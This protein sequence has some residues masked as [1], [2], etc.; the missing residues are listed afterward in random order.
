MFGGFDQQASTDRT[1]FRV[2]RRCGSGEFRSPPVQDFP[3]DH[4]ARHNG[5]SPGGEDGRNLRQRDH[6]PSAIAGGLKLC[7]DKL[8]QFQCVGIEKPD[9]FRRF[10]GGHGIF[11]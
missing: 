10:F 6:L 8:F 2:V 3:C 1:S 9:A 4:P 5:Q 7:A 11:V